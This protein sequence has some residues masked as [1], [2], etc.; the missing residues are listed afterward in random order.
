MQLKMGE[1]SDSLYIST[2]VKSSQSFSLFEILKIIT[3][4]LISHSLGIV[5]M[6]IFLLVI[7]L[8]YMEN[9]VTKKNINT[10]IGQ[11]AR[12]VLIKKCR[13]KYTKKS[14]VFDK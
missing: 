2:L 4:Y 11:I 12:K 8:K 3:M 1:Y 6:N 5:L 13:I 14:N 7:F 9:V 10:E